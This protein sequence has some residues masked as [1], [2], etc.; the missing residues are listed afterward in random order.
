MFMMMRWLYW[1]I[2]RIKYPIAY[3]I[4]LFAISFFPQF[5]PW[6]VW[7]NARTQSNYQPSKNKG[8]LFFCPSLGEYQAIRPLIELHKQDYPEFTV[9]V[10]FFSPSGY[11][12]LHEM[13]HR[14]DHISYA[15]FDIYSACEHFFSQR[16][17][18]HVVIST[19]ALWPTFLRYLSD[20]KI[21]FTFVNVKY[22]H[23]PIKR[24]YYESLLHLY[25]N[26][27]FIFCSNEATVNYISSYVTN[28]RVVYGG[29]TRI[30]MI[31]RYYESAGVLPM[32]PKEGIIL[33][34][35]EASEEDIL[36]AQ[37]DDLLALNTR[38]TI[39]PHDVNRAPN[40][41]LKIEK[42]WFNRLDQIVV[43]DKMGKLL[44][45]YP[46]HRLA[47]VGGG[48]DKGIHNIAEPLLAFCELVIGPSYGANEYARLFIEHGYIEVAERRE[49]IINSLKSR[50]ITHEKRADHEAV[51]WLIRRADYVRSSFEK[52]KTIYQ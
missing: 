13:D 19:F 52:I 46:S 50:Y 27:N 23:G 30:E 18:N 33:A 17:I 43:V 8:V 6:K 41:R 9:E 31:M 34:S 22:S 37:L 26:A 16:N 1:I 49:D 7:K 11:T 42:N 5:H 51:A 44:D 15:P 14:A 21:P 10:S 25:K 12:A 28:G 3:K 38:I 24:L 2:W 40:L 47:Y 48:F 20:N 32:N 39:V 45:L 29:D 35:I 36:I 4:A